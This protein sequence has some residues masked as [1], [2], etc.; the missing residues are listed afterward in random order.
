MRS[1][2]PQ[3]KIVFWEEDPTAVFCDKRVVVS[4]LTAGIIHLEA[5]AAGEQH[6]RDT[7]VIEGGREFVESSDH[8]ASSGNQVIDGDVQDEG[9]LTQTVLRASRFHLSGD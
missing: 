6:G 7:V 8:F 1:L 5:G 2:W 3:V 9:S 4:E